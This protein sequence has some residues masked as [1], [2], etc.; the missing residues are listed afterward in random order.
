MDILYEDN[1]LIAVNKPFGM[2]SQGDDTGDQSVVDWVKEYIRTTYN[3]PGNVYLGLL[4]RLDRPASGVLL[5]AKTS[6]AATRVSKMFQKKEPEKTYLIVTEGIPSPRSA[7]LTHH[8]RKLAGKNIMKAYP[9]PVPDSK[10]ASLEYQ[11]L[12]TKGKRALVEVKLHTGRRHQIR[13]QMGAIGCPV[14]G[15]VKYGKTDFL[16]NKCIALQAHSLSI[17]HPVRK[18]RMTVRAPYPKGVPWGEFGDPY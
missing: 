8:V 1:H 2:L 10:E 12:S 13:V 7:T 5:L 15:D 14:A 9:K 16:P 17:I 18:E 3:K 4:H 6:K 11:V